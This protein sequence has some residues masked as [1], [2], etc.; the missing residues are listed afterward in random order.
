MLSFVLEHRI[1][2][3]FMKSTILFTILFSVIIL[4]AIT[5]FA[6]NK[7]IGYEY[8]YNN[9]YV[10][11][12]QTNINPTSVFNL[13][14]TFST[15]GLTDG[16]NS[17]NVRFWDENKIYSPV[18][19]HYFYKLSAPIATNNDI[20]EFQYWINDD[21]AN[22]VTLQANSQQI[23]QLN[24]N[25]NFSDLPDGLNCL[26]IRFKQS[27]NLWSPVISHYFYKL[28]A[29]TVTN[30]DITEF[31]YWI[32][33]DFANAVTL[34]ANG[35]QIF[36]L[37]TNINFSDLP[38]GLNCLNIRFKQSDNLWSPVISHYFYKVPI[39]TGYNNLIVG[40]RY[41]FDNDLTTMVN[42]NLTNPI[43]VYE[44]LTID[45]TQVWKGQH[46]IHFQF[47]DEHGFWSV[48]TTD[49]IIKEPYPIA[50]FSASDQYIC[51][52]E[53][54]FFTSTSIDGD[55]HLWNFGDGN[56]STDS[57]CSNTYTSAGTY[58]VSLT[59][60]DT[61]MGKDSVI[62]MPIYVYGP[63]FHTIDTFSCD[64][65]TL[66]GIIYTSSGTYTQ[67]LINANGCDSIITIN[68]T[69]HHVDVSVVQNGNTLTANAY[70]A[71]YQ[72]VDCNNNFT[73]LPNE[74]GQNFEATTNGSYAV[75]I[76]QNNCVDTSLCYLITLVEIIENSW[77]NN[78]FIYPNP[79]NGK[80]YVDFNTVVDDVTL[81]I[82]DVK[83]SII[84]KQNHYNKQILELYLN[85]SPG[86][87]FI[88]FISEN[89]TATIRVILN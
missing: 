64:S 58:Y 71:M 14:A 27:D 13:E 39:L 22:A 28:P 63:T 8:W 3:L 49:T 23:F 81:I 41:W 19:S 20:T 24:T 43:P 34:Q 70:P 88:T 29:F 52:G 1:N 25:I 65:F 60:G 53:T 83:G 38:D 57:V 45:L 51:E 17:I 11:K 87:Y 62:T 40:Y 9:N 2:S 86:I 30:N 72:W 89:K 82:K 67:N 44:L 68:L 6:Q 35:Q 78:I 21:F 12:I 66:N 54:V 10:D 48:V 37:N 59:V 80:I 73:P 79:T 18:I 56:T 47:R 32:N 61:I 36:Q 75:I 7:I 4:P 31:Q 16:I 42:V 33:N 55:Y 69:V 77:E 46:T 50:Q 84:Q 76:T 85:F 15:S 5:L 26:N 74:T